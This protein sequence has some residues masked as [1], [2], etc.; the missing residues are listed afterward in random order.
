MEIKEMQEEK[1]KEN[2]TPS[3]SDSP[4]F[5]RK[6]TTPPRTPN[7]SPVPTPPASPQKKQQQQQPPPQN[8]NTSVV[9]QVKEEKPPQ[10]ENVAVIAPKPT[11]K[12]SVRQ[13]AP[14]KPSKKAEHAHNPATSENGQLHSQYHSYYIKTDVKLPPEEPDDAEYNVPQVSLARMPP[15]PK[16]T[17]VPPAKSVKAKPVTKESKPEPKV[18]RTESTKPKTLAETKKASI[19]EVSEVT[20]AESENQGRDRAGSRTTKE[21]RDKNEPLDSNGDLKVGRIIKRIWTP[22]LLCLYHD[23]GGSPLQKAYWKRRLVLI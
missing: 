7:E 9:K 13:E 8:N 11:P 1:K 12:P 16:Q 6:G 15:P 2:P 22:L 14:P 20:E 4:H 3:P 17:R 10:T 19:E 23:G 5:Y 21:Y 18:K